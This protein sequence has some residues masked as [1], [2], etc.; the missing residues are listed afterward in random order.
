MNQPLVTIRRRWDD[1]RSARIAASHLQDLRLRDDP[2]G[3]CANFPRAFLVAR[4]WC[5]RLA[6]NEGWHVCHAASA[7]HELEVCVLESD[8]GAELVARLR[9]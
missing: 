6:E 4:V 5:D 7:P 3:I 8:N 1:P 2:G 9:E